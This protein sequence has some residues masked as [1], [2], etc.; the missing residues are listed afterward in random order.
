MLAGLVAYDHSVF[1]Y[2]VIFLTMTSFRKTLFWISQSLTRQHK[3][4]AIWL[5]DVSLAPFSF[6][7][8]CIFTYNTIWPSEQLARLALVFPLLAV[9]GGFAS[10]ALGLLR[11]K[12][13]SYETFGTI[14]IFPYAAMVTTGAFFVTSLPGLYFPVV[15]TLA[16]AL[17][18]FLSAIG[19]RV[20]LLQLY[21][22]AL[23][24]NK[25]PVRVLIYGAGTTGLRLASALKAHETI[26]VVA[27]LDDDP[28]LSSQ[29]IAGLRI[30]SPEWISDIARN[31]EINRV[32]LAIPS[33][34]A[35]KQMRIVRQ[36][37]ALGL[38]VQVLPSFEQLAGAEMR[39]DTLKSV[40]P[41]RFLN[42]DRLDVGL[43]DGTDAYYG[44]SVMVSGAGGSVGS[45]LC[46]QLLSCGPVRLVLFEMS[47]LALYTIERELAAMP[48]AQDIHIE[49]V[50]GSVTDART[51]RRTIH[52]NGVEVVL[53]AAAYKHVPL[54]EANPISGLVNNVLGTRALA[55]ACVEAGVKRFLLVSTD[56]AVRPTNV[57]GASKRLAELVI[58]DM[59]HRHQGTHFSIVR[60]GN[61]LGSSGSV[62]PLFK[63]QI[64]HGGPVTLTHEDVTRYFMTIAEATRLV[65]LAGS[66]EDASTRGRANVFVLD[67]GKPVRIRDL[68]AQL[69]EAAGYT[70]R[71]ENNPTGDIEIKVIGLRPGEKLHE[72]LLIG[73][74]LLRT[75][76]PKILR[77][78]EED[79]TR[80]E[81][82][83]LLQRLGRIA[84]TGDAEE[85][86]ELAIS[87]AC[88]TGEARPDPNAAMMSQ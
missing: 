40:S 29:R 60:F 39:V 35:P 83:V 72:E 52:E 74:G 62:I 10:I 16:F 57:M 49:P 81:I 82:P 78:S 34:S 65:L 61:V 50:L 56:K 38:E 64:A 46:R 41:G 84:A 51:L 67:M 79:E 66:F 20:I 1:N 23:R 19:S 69:I 14:G 8:A 44:R 24:Y 22:S 86:R 36:M 58:Q 55:D 25:V 7:L 21:L 85:A 4:L 13:K 3:Q 87:V 88:S 48:G 11:V 6:L 37:Q 43:P 70:L 32:I 28:N 80:L 12:L 76:H 71:D 33:L 27:F 59:A 63:D 42:R 17:I 15:G 53:H 9:F 77:A 26:R 68:A 31:H 30:L 54:V 45:E 47:E 2:L 75:P 73:D 18:L 5:L